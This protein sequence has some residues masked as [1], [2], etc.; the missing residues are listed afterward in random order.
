MWSF[1]TAFY[2]YNVNNVL[3]LYFFLLLNN[4]IVWI[5]H[6]LFI[7]SLVGHGV[8]SYVLTIM[9]SAFGEHKFLC[10]HI[11]SFLLDKYLGEELLSHMITLCFKSC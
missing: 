10:V 3:A 11:F 5:Y 9:N 6:I 7:H 2:W 8:F 1:V 4:S